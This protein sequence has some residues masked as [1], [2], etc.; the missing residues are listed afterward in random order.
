MAVTD[1]DFRD[2]DR[3]LEIQRHD[4]SFYER[5]GIS[6]WI[7]LLLFVGGLSAILYGITGNM[8]LSSN[9]P[10]VP[11]AQTVPAPSSH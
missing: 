1:P 9:P 7:A 11:A 8:K 6:G 2:F 5:T 10:T 3:R 4:N